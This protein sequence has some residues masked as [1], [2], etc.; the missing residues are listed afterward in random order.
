MIRASVFALTRAALRNGDMQL[1]V[2][3]R[4]PGA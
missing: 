3:N 4:W 1:D 2:L